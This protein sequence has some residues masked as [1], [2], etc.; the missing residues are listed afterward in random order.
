MGVC[1]RTGVNLA[2]DLPPLFW[3]Q[4]VGEKISPKDLEEIEQSF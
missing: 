1:I 2:L 3:K 4:I